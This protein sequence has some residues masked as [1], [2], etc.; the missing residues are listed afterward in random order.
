MVLISVGAHVLSDSRGMEF[1]RSMVAVVVQGVGM[2]RHRERERERSWG[3][4][5]VF[6]GVSRFG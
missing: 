3:F 4:G 6:D 1:R 2:E 5:Q